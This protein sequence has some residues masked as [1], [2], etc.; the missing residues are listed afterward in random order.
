MTINLSC[1]Y[2]IWVP[3]NRKLKKGERFVTIRSD[4]LD[5]MS[6]VENSWFDQYLSVYG[7]VIDRTDYCYHGMMDENGKWLQSTIKNG[8]RTLVMEIHTPVQPHHDVKVVFPSSIKN[9][10]FNI[11]Y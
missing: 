4:N 1:G 8:F 11:L 10:T 9:L 6:A 5:L 3:F 2:E 7:T